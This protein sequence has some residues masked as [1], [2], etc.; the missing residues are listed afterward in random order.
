VLELQDSD[1]A[2]AFKMLDLYHRTA[3]SPLDVLHLACA[4]HLHARSVDPVTVA[5]SDGALLS[6]ARAAGL[7][8]FDPETEPFGALL[9]LTR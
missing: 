6:V 3:V 9:A 2:A 4:L 8:T 7:A 5:S 1:F